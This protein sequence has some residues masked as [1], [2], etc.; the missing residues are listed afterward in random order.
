MLYQNNIPRIG[1][2]KFVD[3][4]M[5]LYTT[6]NL[7]KM[8]DIDDEDTSLYEDDELTAKLLEVTFQE[9]FRSV[10]KMNNGIWN[11]S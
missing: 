2:S 6:V 11:G 1:K 5:I 10:L 3:N 7:I 9:L 4:L 8:M